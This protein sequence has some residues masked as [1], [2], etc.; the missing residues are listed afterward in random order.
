M[1][2]LPCRIHSCARRVDMVC[3][4]DSFPL[5]KSLLHSGDNPTWSWHVIPFLCCWVCYAR[6]LLK[7]FSIRIHSQGMLVCRFLVCF[8]LALRP[9]DSSKFCNDDFAPLCI[10]LLSLLTDVRR[11][12]LKSGWR[13]RLPHS[14]GRA[15][16][17]SGPVALAAAE[18]A[19]AGGAGG[20]PFAWFPTQNSTP[21]SQLV[22]R[23]E[24][25]TLVGMGCSLFLPVAAI[26]C[27]DLAREVRPPAPAMDAASRVLSLLWA[28]GR[29]LDKRPVTPTALTRAPSVHL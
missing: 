15:R 18:P 3:Y 28:P 2:S 14:A 24:T 5:L 8:G 22:F 12:S 13:S 21:V 11:R 20:S 29:L 19:E 26:R 25:D 4:V 27:S 17:E 23:S 6:I 7:I 1:F 16:P 9:V 10:L